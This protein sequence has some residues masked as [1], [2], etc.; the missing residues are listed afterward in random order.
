MDIR[1]A[2]VARLLIEDI[3]ALQTQERRINEYK[4]Y[5]IENGAQREYIIERLARLFPE[6]YTTMRISDVSLSAKVNSKLS[7]AYKDKPIRTM[8]ESTEVLN[9]VY[10]AG[11]FDNGFKDFERDFNRQGYGL[12]WVNRVND[13]LCLHS[14]KGFEA[15]VVRDQSSGAL[16]AVIINYPDS[17][18]TTTT[19]SDTDYMENIIAESQNDTSANSRVY[20]MW[21]DD[22][23]A[24]WRSKTELSH[25]KAVVKEIYNM[26]IDG[27]EGMINPLGILPFVFASKST[28]VDLPFLNPITEQS[29]VYNILQSDILTA[30]ALQGYG[31]MV[32]KMPTGYEIQALNSGMTTAINLPLVEGA[33]NQAEAS[34]INANPDLSGMGDVIKEFATQVL[35][36]H[37]ITAGQTSGEFSS[38]LERLIANADV[39]DI[40]NSNQARFSNVEDK[41]AD[42]VQAYGNVYGD[43]SISESDEFRVIFPKAK[44]MISDAETLQNIKMRMELGLITEV[45]ALQIIDPNLTDNDAAAKLEAI[46]E[47]RQNKVQ[48]LMGGFNADREEQNQLPNGTEEV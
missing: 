47:E 39:S 4:S 24:V 8:G 25:K 18:I 11:N 3:E 22:F 42:I 38:G 15:F 34:Y 36:Q 45:E 30:S 46:K 19:T 40:I 2:D 44:V 12:L 23:H 35:S 5:K 14:L 29:I 43:F 41:V 16:R 9:E 17:E 31:Q 32:V 6:S 27:N 26:P 10:E 13:M 33:E 21:T 20:A 37:G 7:K 28:A 48:S 1:Q